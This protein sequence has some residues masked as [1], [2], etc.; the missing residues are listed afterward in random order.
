MTWPNRNWKKKQEKD[1]VQAEHVTKG[2][3][4]SENVKEMN[5]GREQTTTG[6]HLS[7]I[8]LCQGDPRLQHPLKN[9]FGEY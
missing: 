2:K 3:K 9:T 8:R 5:K 7:I 4:R 6:C 1:K